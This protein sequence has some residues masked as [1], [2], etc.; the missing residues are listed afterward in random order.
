MSAAA[1]PWK[2]QK[3]PLPFARRNLW[4]AASWTSNSCSMYTSTP[5]QNLK[6]IIPYIDF[7]ATLKPLV[8]ISPQ[9]AKTL[10]LYL[11]STCIIELSI[12]SVS[13]ENDPHQQRTLF[14]YAGPS[15]ENNCI[16]C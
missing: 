10:T 3:I 1:A 14:T 16:N 12:L 8:L 13:I 5:N 9:N 15:P 11:V 6:V 7:L 4:V 2:A